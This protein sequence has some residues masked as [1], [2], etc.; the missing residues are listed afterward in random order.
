MKIQRIAFL[1]F[2]GAFLTFSCVSQEDINN[3][4]KQIDG[5]SDNQIKSLEQ[6]ISSVKASITDLQTMDKGLKAYID[7]LIKTALDLQKAIDESDSKLEKAKEVFD[8]AIADVKAEAA[9]DN[10]SLK[11]DL[12][13]SIEAAKADVIAQLTSARAELQG[14]V[15]QIKS[16]IKSLK[17]KD[18]EL[19]NRITELE[20]YTDALNKD[21]RDWVSATFVTLEQYNATVST[22]SSI[23]QTIE[24]MNQRL[25][26]IESN[27][28]GA[29]AEEIKNAI[30]PIKDQIAA[31]V[32][33][34]VI[35]G[36]T[37]AIITA[38]SAIEAA[39][40]IAIADA[41]SA[42]EVSMKSWVNDK[43]T[44]YYTASQVDAKLT[45]LKT[46][47]EAQLSSQKSYLESLIYSLE[48]Q[49]EGE[50]SANSV[51]ITALRSDL[52]TLQ[53]DVARNA[54]RIGENASQ[55]SILAGEVSKNASAISTNA[56][57]IS[58]L[59][60][61]ISSL[62]SEMNAKIAALQG[63]VSGN[64]DGSDDVIAEIDKLKDDYISRIES[65]KTDMT[66]L[67]S[68][69]SDLIKANKTAIET[70]ATAIAYN[71]TAI[72]NLKSSTETAIANNAAAISANAEDI[73]EKAAL[74]AANA[75]AISNN[76]NAISSNAADIAQLRNDLETAKTE[77]TVAYKAAI[78]EAIETNGG[79]IPS[80]IENEISTINSRIDSEI[81][82]VNAAI[83][84]LTNRVAACEKDIKSIKAQIYAIQN[85]IEDIQEQIAAILAR[86]HSVSYVPQYSDGKA[87]MTYTDNGVVTPGVATFDF[88][89]QPASTA[90]ELVKVWQ[91]AISM[92]AVYTV[93]KAP[94]IV[95]LT[96]EN[97]TEDNGFITVTVSGKNLSDDYFRF[98]CSANV[99]MKISDGNNEI[100]TDYIQM[101]P[102][103]RDVISFAD[104]KFK[105]YCVENFDIDGDGE[106]SEDEAKAV[107][108]IECSLGGLTSLVGIEYFSN[109]EYIDVSY[110]KLTSLD[111]SHSPLLKEVYVNGN[112]L[113]S[114]DL[115]GIGD[116]ETLD[117][118]SNKLGTLN[119]S[120]A[121]HL[122]SLICSSNNLGT[123]NIKNNKELTE[124]QC[125]S[126]N[127]ASL[128][129]KNNTALEVLY[130]RKNS[131]NVL[132]V[133]MLPNLKELDCSNNNI[134]SLNLYKNTHLE[135]LY[136]SS[137]SL[138]SLGISANTAL[139][140]LDCS[141]N[142]ITAIDLSRNILVETLDC[143]GNALSSLDLSHNTALT[144]LRCDG[145][146]A[147]AK[148]WL[149]DVSHEEGM[150]IRKEDATVIAYYDGT[151][152][153][154]PDANLKAYL[155]ALFDD[156]EDGEISVLESENIV[157]VNCSGRSISY[158]TGLEAC[159]NLKYLN[160]NGNNVST[161]ELPNLQKLETIVCY[162]NPVSRL[163]VNNDTALTALYLQDVN[164]N[165]L[166]GTTVTINAYDQA[167]TLY[168]A[169]A[170]TDYTTLNLTNSPALTS[171]DITENIQ[172]T[173]LVASGNTS[174]TGVDLLPLTALTYLD[175][176]SCGL[177]SLNVDTNVELVTFDCSGNALTS[178]NV[179]N[180]AAL[181]T[182]N[183]SSN[184]LTTLRVTN[185]LALETL[186]VSYNQLANINV[187][188]NTLLKNLNVGSNAA[189]TALALGYNEALETLDASN[190]ALA[191]I[192]LSANLAVKSL[193]LAGCSSMHIIDL[194]VNKALVTLD[195]S[196]T[197]L[198]VLDVSNNTSL[199]SL[200][201]SREVL[202]MVTTGMSSSIYKIGQYV[203]IEG[204]N[205]IVFQT[206]LPKIVS[207]DETSASWG[208]YGTSTGATSS[209]DGVSNTNKIASGSPAAKWCRAKGTAWYLPAFDELKIVYNNRSTL[210]TTLSLIVGAQLISS[211]YYWSSTEDS[212]LLAYWI[213]FSSG[214]AS[215][216]NYNKGKTSYVRAVRA[217]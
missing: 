184:E 203:S 175:V 112:S 60:N 80:D 55:I 124:L 68:A 119:V 79:S 139:L 199:S 54:N 110:N 2:V 212:S 91:T 206:S 197:S 171:Y 127:L 143:S 125:S 12:L 168:L 105:A 33:E 165:A 27:I 58:N 6:Q 18:V 47:L 11:N 63:K 140:I 59:E 37:N 53:G 195:V 149:R 15:D 114:L 190:T 132:N 148:V 205:G 100:A 96:I 151:G 57:A 76:T 154:I 41:V 104:E 94:T 198:E 23:Q 152:I 209:T 1:L 196:G 39:Y 86:I 32:T 156:D 51:L 93:T 135:N 185:N 5:I 21:T 217:L 166:S 120:E 46:T 186:N 201:V 19:D 99:R 74:I 109:L 162:D 44:A 188:K 48:S 164:T 101:V 111:L 22:V 13:K 163:V 20:S 200:N 35:E 90:A 10:T 7:D 133:S 62:E 31:E 134:S 204:V 64:E 187:R 193:M 182:F 34:D 113:Q 207:I 4:Q 126:N 106:I 121:T 65:L 216:M 159:I 85:D 77:M 215:N 211:G 14:Q 144:D 102:W 194:T 88:E 138:M 81:E 181:V 71:K 70:N 108:R 137:N 72:A 136:C 122:K 97:V 192:D 169:F 73:A 103:T 17:S 142:S 146:E 210:N 67:I 129:L 36:Y 43:L 147:L 40:T 24:G 83:K 189:I 3:L 167:S 202:L 131:L 92:S 170:G 84:A 8:K 61:E 145:N 128:D 52:S 118:S 155:L 160:L 172:L 78:K 42:L 29:F 208:Y 95:P 56:S 213:D 123:L 98:R 191:D 161:I 49:L 38:K 69:N 89:L 183:C 9:T 117:C 25:A 141:K 153:N 157:N 214:Y 28:S 30:E 174:V 178:L 26:E 180:N 173:K 75:S 82:V 179:D 16:T 45:A 87:I 50:I 176:H 177:T 150:T 115:S 107:T 66:K 116:L 158:I 130:C